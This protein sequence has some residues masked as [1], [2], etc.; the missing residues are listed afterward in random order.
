M[1]FDPFFFAVLLW[2]IYKGGLFRTATEQKEQIRYFSQQDL[3]ELFS[4][5]N[6][7]FDVSLT[8]K[9]LNEEHDHQHTMEESLQSHIEFL[10]TQGIAGVSHHSLLFS[11]TAPPLPVVEGEQE[12]VERIRQTLLAQSST[13]SSSL[14]WN[15]NG[16]EYAFK[17][18]DVILNRKPSSPADAAKL[19]K[20]EIK[21][22][23]NRLSK[24]LAN[25]A[26]VSRLPDK[27]EKIERQIFEL[28]TELRR[29]EKEVIDLD[30][31]LRSFMEW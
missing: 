29:F 17:P 25:K 18:K 31:K 14:E 24:T 1:P 9:Q 15:V 19:T 7:G 11:K 2:L 30:D 12:E 28:N 26:L 16:A 23:I 8:Q 10:E 6:Q 27:G 21:E 4:L 13:S 3:R 20:S 5:P 22:N